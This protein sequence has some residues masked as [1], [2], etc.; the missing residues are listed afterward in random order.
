LAEGYATVLTI[1]IEQTGTPGYPSAVQIEGN[2]KTLIWQGNTPPTPTNT[3]TD[4][5]TFSILRTG[6]SGNEYVV[7]GQMTGF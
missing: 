7:L 5:V 1:V 6:I 2:A 4:V 3:G